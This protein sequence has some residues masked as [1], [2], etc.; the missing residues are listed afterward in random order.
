[1]TNR[2]SNCGSVHQTRQSQTVC[3]ETYRRRREDDARS[4]SAPAYDPWTYSQY[5]SSSTY[6]SSSSS[7]DSYSSCDSS[8]SFSGSCD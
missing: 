3:N 4:A 1:M 5:D 6:S 8:S 2:C 7:S